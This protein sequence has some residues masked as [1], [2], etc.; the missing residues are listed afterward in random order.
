[1]GVIESNKSR[2]IDLFTI[3]HYSANMIAKLLTSEGLSCSRQGVILALRSW[4]IETSRAG[5]GWVDNKCPEC[6]REFP[7]KRCNYRQK[8]EATGMGLFCNNNTCAKRHAYKQELSAKMKEE[9][10]W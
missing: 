8:I 7:V 9:C 2:I 6:G 4:K 5:A 1:M 3:K 10:K